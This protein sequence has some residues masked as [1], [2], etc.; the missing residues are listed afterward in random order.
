MVV[1]LSQWVTVLLY[2]VLGELDNGMTVSMSF[3]LDEGA[4]A[5]GTAT[6]Y[7]ITIQ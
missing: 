3:E 2:L 5:A 4:N 1:Q 7:L 6:S